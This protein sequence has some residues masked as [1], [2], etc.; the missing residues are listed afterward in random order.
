[1]FLEHLPRTSWSDVEEKGG[2][3]IDIKQKLTQTKLFYFCYFNISRVESNE[4]LLIAE[5][6][7]CHQIE[8]QSVNLVFQ[9][10]KKKKKS[11][12]PTCR[13]YE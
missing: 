10:E 9:R 13:Q 6:L 2:R 3:L 11:V 12:G 7:N 5:H 8:W 4:V 1:M